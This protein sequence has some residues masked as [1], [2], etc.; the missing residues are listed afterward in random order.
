MARWVKGDRFDKRA[1]KQLRLEDRRRAD[2]FLEK[3]FETPPD[4][5]LN[6]K[7]MDGHN[8]E[9]WEASSGK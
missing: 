7:P 9:L 1:A 6:L 3:L 2:R 4:T 8:R 5:A